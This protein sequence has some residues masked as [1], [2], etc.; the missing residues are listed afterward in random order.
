[1][2]SIT[3]IS[4]QS[5]NVT[6]LP[7]RINTG[8]DV[9]SGINVNNNTSSV[10]SSS[11]LVSSAYSDYIDTIFN[12][13]DYNTAVSAY[14][15]QKQRDWQEW[16]NKLAMRF[17]AQE[18]QKNRDW[19]EM[20]S[21]TAHRREVEDLMAAGLNPVLSAG[22]GNGASV[23][24]GAT[25]SG[26]TSAGAKG[27]VD[28]SA[29]SSLVG[30]LSSMLSAQT[31]ILNTNTNALNNMAI[32]EKTNESNRTIAEMNNATSKYGYD[33]SFE[34]SK[35][36]ADKGYS[37]SIYGSNASAGAILG[38]ANINR[39]SAYDVAAIQSN[40]SLKNTAANIAGGLLSTLYN[41]LL[42]MYG[43]NVG[44]ATADKDRAAR[45]D[46]SNADRWA[47]A[48]AQYLGAIIPW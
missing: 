3:N 8:G 46:Q 7:G 5:Q 47:Y 11:D 16:Q 12:I 44:A 25:A 34:A 9:N 15:A 39:Q 4:G 24:S 18:A 38:S 32:A 35:Y 42:S 45:V 13:A 2:P 23:T 28:T 20:M 31:Q 21:N 48:P 6:T 33:K 40:T 41:G 37:A 27:D 26:V 10:P 29:T 43:I 17:N 19:Q 1:M 14:E 22:N 36:A 30:L